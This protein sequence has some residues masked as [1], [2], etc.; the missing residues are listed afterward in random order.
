MLHGLSSVGRFAGLYLHPH[1]FDPYP[2]RVGLDP[3]APVAQ[4]LHA[5]VREAQRNAAR[6]R[7]PD[8]LKAIAERFE[9]IPYGEAYAELHGRAAA[10][11]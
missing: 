6:R 11:T 8:M 9:L 7:A 5:R 3:R 4:R 10:R 1:E 2:L